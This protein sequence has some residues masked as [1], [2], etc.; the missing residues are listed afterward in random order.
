MSETL[1]TI[2]EKPL[3]GRRTPQK[4]A[5]AAEAAV[6]NAIDDLVVDLKLPETVEI[7]LREQSDTITAAI[8]EMIHMQLLP[9]ICQKDWDT[10][11]SETDVS[12]RT[13]MKIHHSGIPNLYHFCQLTEA[14]LRK[15]HKFG[16]LE[17]EEIEERF[18]KPN[19]LTL[20][21]G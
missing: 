19:G 12:S 20:R 21:K 10:L 8:Y 2:Y 18:L 13:A 5:D 7:A 3:P 9:A 11:Y 16:D 17:L 14:E 6:D 15:N 1:H 4:I